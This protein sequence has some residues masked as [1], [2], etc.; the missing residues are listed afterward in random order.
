M[1]ICPRTTPISERKIIMQVYHGGEYPMTVYDVVYKDDLI[2]FLMY[3]G[4]EWTLIDARE[5]TVEPVWMPSYEEEMGF[6][7][8]DYDDEEN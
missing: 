2:Y 5:C 1:F 7:A 4:G 3:L 6:N 8:D